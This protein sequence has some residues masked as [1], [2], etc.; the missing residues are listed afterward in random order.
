VIAIYPNPN[1][2]K[3]R[4]KEADTCQSSVKELGLDIKDI[5]YLVN[6]DGTIHIHGPA[7]VYKK[8]PI[9]PDNKKEEQVIS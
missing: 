6:N 5:V 9:S 4:I 8:E 2:P 3:N 7:R 1:K